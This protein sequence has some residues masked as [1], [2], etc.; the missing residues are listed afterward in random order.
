MTNYPFSAISIL[1]K[2]KY[3]TA[4]VNKVAK[5]VQCDVS[6]CFYN[7]QRRCNANCIKVAKCNCSQA[8]NENETECE[9]FKLK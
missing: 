2:Y 1:Q 7:E 4:E 5:D 9:T 8:S 6:T 3:L